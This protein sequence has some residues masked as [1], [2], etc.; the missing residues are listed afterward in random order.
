MFHFWVLIKSL[1]SFL[2]G[3]LN[4]TCSFF[5]KVNKKSREMKGYFDD[6]R[7]SGDQDIWLGAT[8]KN[9]KIVYV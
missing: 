1:G 4:Q 7:E 8:K 6:P 9:R 3:S 2:M 5:W